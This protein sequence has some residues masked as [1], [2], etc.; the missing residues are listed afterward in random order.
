MSALL[1]LPLG[2]FFSHEHCKAVRECGSA[3]NHHQG[4]HSECFWIAGNA[5]QNAIMCLDWR[6]CDHALQSGVLDNPSSNRTI[7]IDNP[8]LSTC[9]SSDIWKGSDTTS[10]RWHSS[11][12]QPISSMRSMRFIPVVLQPLHFAHLSNS[13]VKTLKIYRQPWGDDT[14]THTEACRNCME[15]L[16]WLDLA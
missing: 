13:S 11:S 3:A 9:G 7:R 14:H 10:F 6:E 8:S 4:G 2:L 12:V 16:Q 5:Q 1:I 15:L